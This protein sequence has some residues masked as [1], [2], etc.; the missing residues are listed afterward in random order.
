MH[1]CVNADECFR[2]ITGNHSDFIKNETINDSFNQVIM[3]N[4]NRNYY[5]HYIALCMIH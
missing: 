3:Y 4:E 5:V 2:T 1:V